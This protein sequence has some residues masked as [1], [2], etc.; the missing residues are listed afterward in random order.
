ME[1]FISLCDWCISLRTVSSSFV[2]IVTYKRISLCLR[3]NNVF[4]S[5]YH[6]L[7][8]HSSISS[9][10]YYFH[11]LFWL[12][13]IMLQWTRGCRYFFQVVIKFSLAIC[14]EVGFL[15]PMVVLFLI[16][17]RKPYAILHSACFKLH[18]HQQ[19]TR[20]PFPLISLPTLVLSFW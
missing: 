18:S 2:Q 3:L 1:S 20:V 13:W 5:I 15:D 7:F 12:L 11:L 10:L 6:I 8:F 14:P 16:F 4:G 9:Y 17:W 19:C